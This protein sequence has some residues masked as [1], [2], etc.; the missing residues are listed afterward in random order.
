[1]S[2]TL[3][4]ET[5][6]EHQ[7][8]PVPDMP[9]RLLMDVQGG[10]CNLKCP[11]CWVHAP[12]ANADF[13]HLRGRMSLEDARKVLD[14]VMNAKPTFQPN[15]WTEPLM[16]KNFKEHIRQVKERGIPTSMNTNGL[17][18][19]E[20]MANFLV[21]VKF[22]C[23]LIS[24]DATTKETLMKS[25]GTD[26]LEEIERAVFTMLKARGD[27]THPRIGVTFTSEECN[28]HERDEFVKKWINYVDVI[29]VGERYESYGKVHGH[30]KK[31]ELPKKRTPC[32]ALYDTM[33]VHFNGDVSVC[34][35][36]GMRETN[37]GNILKDGVH[38][39]W[40][41]EAFTK[42]RHYH[43]T[44]QWDKVPF[45]KGCKVWA[46]YDYE[47]I[48]ENGVLIRR[49]PLMTYYNRVDRLETWNEDNRGGHK[50]KNAEVL[51]H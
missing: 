23:V 31:V 9:P 39:V 26:K 2:D 12:D 51:K 29:R 34:C 38:K 35:L 28:A 50:V 7:H 11:K 33:A 25:R 41:G 8:V 22:D 32:Q 13:A 27:R 30:V 36:D 45:C 49:S 21:E 16:A 15:L 47:E 46:R 24:I 4:A 48:V 43:E 40:H 5:D 42:A 6:T 19:N 18:L 44:G 20:E 10:Y 14:E 17:L 3:V 1:M 37:M